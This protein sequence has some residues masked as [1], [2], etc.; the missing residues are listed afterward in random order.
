[1]EGKERERKR[2]NA[3]A[4]L[5]SYRPI[6]LCLRDSRRYLLHQFHNHIDRLSTN[7]DIL[8]T[9]SENYK[10]LKIGQDQVS[11]QMRSK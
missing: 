4:F 5:E 2:E 1:M 7:A 6:I 9:G 8:R 10:T 3:Q 11:E